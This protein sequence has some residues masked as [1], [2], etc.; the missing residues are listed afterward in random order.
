M[1]EGMDIDTGE[2]GFPSN[3]AIL[4]Q[5]QHEAYMFTLFQIFQM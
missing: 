5:I 1:G 3:S 4:V 2:L